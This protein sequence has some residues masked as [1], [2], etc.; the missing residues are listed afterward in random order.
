MLQDRDVQKLLLG[1]LQ[2]SHCWVPYQSNA[3]VRFRDVPKVTGHRIIAFA[4]HKDADGLRP[5]GTAYNELA[6]NVPNH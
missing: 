5:P 6:N 3:N 4:F 1:W 2:A